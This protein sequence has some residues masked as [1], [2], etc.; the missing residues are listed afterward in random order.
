MA[1]KET[2][3]EQIILDAAEAEFLEKGYGKSRT[4]E[5]AKRAGVNHAMLHYYFRTKEHLFEVV[6][7]KKAKVMSEVL[8]ISFREDLPF[9]EKIKKGIEDHFDFIKANPRLP[10]FI[11]NE[12]MY[13]EK[14]KA[15][16]KSIIKEKVTNVLAELKS[17][18]DREV[19]KGTIRPTEPYDLIFNML[20]LNVF[21][22]IRAPIVTGIMDMGEKEF[23]AFLEHR[24]QLN[25]EMIL[26][27]LK[28]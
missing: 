23:S 4:T 22:F 17:E 16:F 27:Q 7:Q 19:T 8:M 10:N 13:D 15:I 28:I 18:I 1:V 12:I 14:L 25:V 2:N 11:F 9:L 24:K 26:N 3:T 21:V 6:F 5:I 20:S